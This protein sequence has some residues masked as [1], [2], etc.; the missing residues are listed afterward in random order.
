M[1]NKERYGTQS[2][3]AKVRGVEVSKKEVTRDTDPKG[4][5]VDVA[6]DDKA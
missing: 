2:V 6:F 1:A 5:K 3:R 4:K